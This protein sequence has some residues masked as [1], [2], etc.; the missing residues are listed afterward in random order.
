LPPWGPD[1]KDLYALFNGAHD[2]T[3]LAFTVLVAAHIL[4]AIYHAFIARDGVL[5]RMATFGRRTT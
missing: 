3:G 2:A 1:D 5:S 4:A